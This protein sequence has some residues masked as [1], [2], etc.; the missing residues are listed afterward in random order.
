[1]NENL[2]YIEERIHILILA[3]KVDESNMKYFKTQRSFYKEQINKFTTELN[4]YKEKY[5]ELFI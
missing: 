3:I 1:M 4:E 2:K 5:P